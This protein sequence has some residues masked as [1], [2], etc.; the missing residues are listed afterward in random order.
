MKVTKDPSTGVITV[1]EPIMINGKPYKLVPVEEKEL[2]LEDCCKGNEHMIDFD[3]DHNY[4]TEAIAEKVLLYGLLQSVAY[5]LNEQAFKPTRNYSIR[6]NGSELIVICL[7][8]S[9][10]MPG[11]HTEELARQAIAIFAKSKFDLKKLF[12]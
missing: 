4:P 11:F 12:Q 6:Y 3:G 8:K 5:K 10:G 1:D 7:D 2:T 9:Y